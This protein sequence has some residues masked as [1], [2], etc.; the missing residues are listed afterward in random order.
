MF[1]GIDLGTSGIKIV[2]ID[3]EGSVACSAQE[4]LTVS[5]PHALWS[6]Q[7][8]QQWWTALDVCMSN[9]ANKI[10]MTDIQGIGLSGQMHGATLV[11][12]KGKVIRPA[13]LWNDGRSACQ[14]KQLEEAVPGA[15]S[16]TGNIIMPGFTAPKVLWVKEHEP[17]HFARI[18]KVLL[19]KDYLR[20][21]LS[22]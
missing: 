21:R 16:I 8:P 2:V 18:S 5:R 4:G 15:R 1:L 3:D 6:E 12:D 11:D 20:F 13:I 17:E 9:L 22:R 7:D 19:P 10:R 14:C